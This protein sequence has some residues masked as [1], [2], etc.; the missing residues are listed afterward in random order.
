MRARALSILVRILLVT[1]AL[2]GLL[3]LLAIAR[4]AA[5]VLGA[6]A[7]AA[8]AAGATLNLIALTLGSLFFLYSLRYYLATLVVLLSSLLLADTNGD[9]ATNGGGNSHPHG[10]MRFL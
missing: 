2:V 8:G 3:P 5:E 1:A 7:S 6:G 9:H 10:L 4:G